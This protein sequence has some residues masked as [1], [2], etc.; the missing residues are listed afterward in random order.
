MLNAGMSIL[1]LLVDNHRNDERMRGLELL[2][3]CPSL[4]RLW[5]VIVFIKGNLHSFLAL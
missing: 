3:P 1:I 2:S 4:N 5:L